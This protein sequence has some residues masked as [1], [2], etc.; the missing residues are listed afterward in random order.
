MWGC[1]LIDLVRLV[2]YLMERSLCLEF[3]HVPIYIYIYDPSHVDTLVSR[4]DQTSLLMSYY[5]I[6]LNAQRDLWPYISYPNTINI[7]NRYEVHRTSPARPILVLTT[8]TQAPSPISHFKSPNLRLPS[9]TIATFRRYLLPPPSLSLTSVRHVA[10][11]TSPAQGLI[12]HL[13]ANVA[14]KGERAMMK[15]R[16]V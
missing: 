16:W 1:L 13:G 2:L 14:V 3:F 12:Q 7:L 5:C 8:L 11:Y 6:Q 4:A 15:W 10:T 9:P